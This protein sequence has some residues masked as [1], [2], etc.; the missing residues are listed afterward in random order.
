[1]KNFKKALIVIFSFVVLFLVYWLVSPFF[2]DIKVNESLPMVESNTATTTDIA[3]T[4]VYKGQ[5]YGFDKIHNGTGTVSVYKIGENYILRFEEGFSVNNG[6]D[7]YVGFGKNGSYI[8]G[9]E[10]S[11]LK[12]NIG[13]QNYDIT[14]AF[15]RNEYDSVYVWCKAFNTPFIK[16]DLKRL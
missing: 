7:L 3:S 5:F 2:I 9:S 1:M 14:D 15:F 10:I 16:A 13:A 8:K 4:S 6:P 12:G 11:K